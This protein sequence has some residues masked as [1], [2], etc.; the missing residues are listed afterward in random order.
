ME[1]N[2]TR[3]EDTNSDVLIKERSRIIVFLDDDPQPLGSFRSPINF[4]LDTTRLIDGR[5]TLRIISKDPHGKEGI[6]LIPFIVRNGPDISV[7]G[8]KENQ[9]V[10]G[11]VPVMINA[12]GKGDA[13]VFLI[14]S[15]EVPRSIPGWIWIVNILFVAWALYYLI[16]HLF[17]P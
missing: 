10:N 6:R 8:L 9:I 2:I 11:T 3:K 4:E 17:N 13:K 5:H 15:S 14:E 16:V 1:E 12:Y 7:E